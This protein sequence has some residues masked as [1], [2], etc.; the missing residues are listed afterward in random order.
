M[1]KSKLDRM[2]NDAAAAYARL[3]GDVAREILLTIAREN[4]RRSDGFT[5]KELA[6][7]IGRDKGFIT[8]SLSGARNLEL[9]T[10]AGMMGA[11][12]Y[13]M[14]VKARPV[15]ASEEYH[16][17]TNPMPSIHKPESVTRS[18]PEV[19]RP[20]NGVYIQNAISA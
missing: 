18:A 9:R 6:D 7:L 13:V 4:K 12:G 19:N 3:A 16:G 2:T 20:T 17:N 10:I 1:A 8:R 5:K 15:R 11:M 14:D